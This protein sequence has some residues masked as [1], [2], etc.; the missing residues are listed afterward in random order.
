MKALRKSESHSLVM[1]ELMATAIFVV[2]FFA[3]LLAASF[4]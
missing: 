4:G 1:S 3:L 2:G